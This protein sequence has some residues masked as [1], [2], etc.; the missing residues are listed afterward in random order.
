MPL[1]TPHQNEAAP[2]P[3]LRCEHRHSAD[4]TEWHER[5]EPSVHQP[6][7]SMFVPV[8]SRESSVSA[9]S[10]LAYVVSLSEIEQ[11]A[12]YS[13]GTQKKKDFENMTARHKNENMSCTS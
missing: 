10:R 4:Q 9:R 3:P 8:D 1:G 13:N 2:P 6:E 5:Y 7:N 12:W 11:N